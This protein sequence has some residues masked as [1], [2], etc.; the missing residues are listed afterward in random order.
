MVRT[1]QITTC[2]VYGK[3]QGSKNV[4]CWVPV[5]LRQ[6]YLPHNAPTQHYTEEE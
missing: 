6:C 5:N 4:T 1:G 2:D 3:L